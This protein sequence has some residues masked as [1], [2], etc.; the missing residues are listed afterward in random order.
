MVVEEKVR[1]AASKLREPQVVLTNALRREVL[2]RILE[3][4]QVVRGFEKRYGTSLED[5]ERQNLLDRL[6]HTWEVEEDYYEWDRGVTELRKL[7][8]WTKLTYNFTA[9]P[10]RTQRKPTGKVLK[11]SAVR[12]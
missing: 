2:G 5:F 8:R 10:Q 9:K 7:S 1:Q 12:I 6:G 11:C 4:N 3:F